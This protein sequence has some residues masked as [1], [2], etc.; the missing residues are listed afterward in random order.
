MESIE[1]DEV[2]VTADQMYFLLALD[3]ITSF[4][5]FLSLLVI[6]WTSFG[7]TKVRNLKGKWTI[8]VCIITAVSAQIIDETLYHIVDDEMYSILSRVLMVITAVS[9]LVAS[10]SFHKL[11]KIINAKC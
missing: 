5:V 2:A 4:I 1:V 10:F 7:L 8:F 9:I 11:A 6:F 3:G